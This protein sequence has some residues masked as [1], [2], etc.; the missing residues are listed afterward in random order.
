MALKRGSNMY[1]RIEGNS[2]YINLDGLSRVLNDGSDGELYFC[3]NDVIKICHSDYMTLEKLRDFNLIKEK[4]FDSESEF[5]ESRVVLPDKLVTKKGHKIKKLRVTPVFGYTQS[6]HVEKCLITSLSI[7]DFIN[8]TKTVKDSV[9]NILTANNVGITDTNPANLLVS[10]DNKVYLIDHDRDVTEN[11]YEL[12]KKALLRSNNYFEN[13]EKVFANMIARTIT[14]TIGS[15]IK[16]K[17]ERIYEILYKYEKYLCFLSSDELYD[18]LSKY[19]T[20][21]ELA[22][23]KSKELSIRKK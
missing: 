13:N 3:G 7:K 12:E 16:R 5:Y 9:H 14:Y 1:I 11:T 21:E 18:I 20:F 23:D 22:E 2:S 17:T 6:Y 10:S 4:M 8:E 19:S 15:P